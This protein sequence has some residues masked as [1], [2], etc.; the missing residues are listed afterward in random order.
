MTW[1]CKCDCGNEYAA[2]TNSLTHGKTTCCC[3]CKKKKIADA[4]RKHGYYPKQLWNAYTNMKTR[5][6]NPNYSLFH[7]YGGRGI[8]VCKEWKE[9]F[10]AFLA[11]SLSNGYSKG[12]TLDRIDNDG[13]YCPENCRWATVIEQSNNRSTNRMICVNWTVDTLANWARRT[14]AKY[15]YVQHLLDKGMSG[16]D[17]FGQLLAREANIA[18]G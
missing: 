12:L 6:Y 9:S 1:L 2:K 3:D 18:S 4:N 7:R 16:D 14:G 8:K 10:D 5:C 15:S 11:W 13:D 17:V